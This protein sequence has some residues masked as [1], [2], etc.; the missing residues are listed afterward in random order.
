MTKSPQ[1]L[2]G[3]T[4][5]VRSLVTDAVMGGGNT[6]DA[7]HRNKV[8]QKGV[9]TTGVGAY[10]EGTG[11]LTMGVRS[12]RSREGMLTTGVRSCREGAGGVTMRVRACRR[13]C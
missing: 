11:V 3:A 6:Q 4:G 13:G 8:L 12:H 10:R 1:T 2:N 5:R 7:N 9:L